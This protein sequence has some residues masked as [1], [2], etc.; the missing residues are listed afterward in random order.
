MCQEILNSEYMVL[1][2]VVKK[3][4]LELSL[5]KSKFLCNK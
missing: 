1:M 3:I 2:A 5:A 4:K